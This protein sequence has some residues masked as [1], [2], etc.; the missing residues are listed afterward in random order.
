MDGTQ[1][2]GTATRARS[3]QPNHLKR[4][5]TESEISAEVVF[6]ARQH[7]GRA[8]GPTDRFRMPDG[9]RPG[10]DA[11]WF[12]PERWNAASDEER[13]PLNGARPVHLLK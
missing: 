8:G 5:A 2:A 1:P 13:L 3:E 10:P 12:S 7:G 11:V 9:S 4:N 6:Y